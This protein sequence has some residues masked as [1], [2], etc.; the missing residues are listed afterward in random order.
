MAR[1]VV[2]RR[3]GFARGWMKDDAEGAATNSNAFDS[4]ST[5]SISTVGSVKKT[6]SDVNC[7]HIMQY[8]GKSVPYTSAGG[9]ISENALG[10]GN[11]PLGS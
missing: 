5:G 4:A 2:F 9:S 7:V 10:E 6:L 8:M 1:G 11:L 3:E